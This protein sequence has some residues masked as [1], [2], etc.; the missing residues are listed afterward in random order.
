M[1]LE[2]FSTLYSRKMARGSGCDNSAQTVECSLYV[3]IQRREISPD[4]HSIHAVS[5]D[6]ADS[7]VSTKGALVKLKFS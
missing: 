5:G 4:D 1:K 3:A 2:T 7:S 6:P